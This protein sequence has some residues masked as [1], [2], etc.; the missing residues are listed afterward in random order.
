MMRM[1]R[2]IVLFQIFALYCICF[3]LVTWVILTILQIYRKE[4]EEVEDFCGFNDFVDTFHFKRG[5]DEDD[6]NE[7]TCGELKVRFISVVV[8]R[9]HIL[10]FEFENEHF[11]KSVFA[12]AVQRTPSFL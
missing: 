2:R 3:L 11:L 12:I 1:T 7:P 5:K 8:P 6:E 10:H 9:P 4:L